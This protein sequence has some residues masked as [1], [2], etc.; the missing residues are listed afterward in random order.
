[1]TS[2]TTL[3]LA[4]AVVATVSTLSW[5]LAATPQRLRDDDRAA[6]GRGD[7]AANARDAADDERPDERADER[8]DER[9][10][11]DD[12]GARLVVPGRLPALPQVASA[13]PPGTVAMP[14]MPPQTGTAE[15]LFADDAPEPEPPRSA[16]FQ[17]AQRTIELLD[18]RVGGAID[19]LERL[20]GTGQ[21]DAA[22]EVWVRLGRDLQEVSR[23]AS[24]IQDELTDDE[25]TEVTN[26]AR[27]R[28]M[29]KLQRLSSLRSALAQGEEPQGETHGEVPDDPHGGEVPD[30]P[31][32]E[33][34]DDP[35]LDAPDPEEDGID[36]GD[37]ANLDQGP[38]LRVDGTGD[39]ED[40]GGEAGD[41]EGE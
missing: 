38:S 9:G 31:H 25:R 17:R 19:E 6:E 4:M 23:E 15:R 5:G 20:Q 13:S 35:D 3:A 10:D 28:L 16:A 36:E 8:A 26:L 30:D 7:E 37:G 14:P 11:G 32:G 27:T 29:P 18:A 22:T 39:G 33:V 40:E 41:E 24:A 12:D 1:M 34:P 21:Q 2:R